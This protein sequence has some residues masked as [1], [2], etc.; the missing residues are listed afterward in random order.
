MT[1]VGAGAA[2]TLAMVPGALAVLL[3][4]ALARL[5][6]FGVERWRRRRERQDLRR[7]LLGEVERTDWL[8]AVVDAGRVCADGGRIVGGPAP[9]TVYDANQDRLDRL[10]APEVAAVDAYYDALAT[11]THRLEEF[12]AATG[13]ERD[14][15]E[16]DLRTRV[17]PELAARRRTA[18]RTLTANIQ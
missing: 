2:R 6:Q 11:A 3:A 17:L 16:R 12:R 15:I 1:E 14:H 4:P 7:R 8:D 5:L 18:E 13:R 9:R 10:Q